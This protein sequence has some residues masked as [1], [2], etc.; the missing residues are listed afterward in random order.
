L[1]TCRVLAGVLLAALMAGPLVQAQNS[2][3]QSEITIRELEQKL[4]GAANS[5]D[6]RF[7]DA[8]VAPEWT[9]STRLAAKW[10]N[11]LPWRC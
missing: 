4:V 9:V 1:L 2:R 11:R 6:W 5:N 7:W 3:A 10:T 8:V